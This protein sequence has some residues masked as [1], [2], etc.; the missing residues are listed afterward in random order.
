MADWNTPAHLWGLPY[1]NKKTRAGFEMRGTLAECITR[2]LALPGY[3]QQNCE[4]ACDPPGRG[5]WSAERISAFVAKNGLPPD[6]AAR[7]GGQ[8]GAADLARIAAI[9][10]YEPPQGPV[11]ATDAAVHSQGFK[12]NDG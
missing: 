12:R 11:M 3:Q 10:R 2:W 5:I 6:M 8:P 7:R 1:T 9:A 4:M